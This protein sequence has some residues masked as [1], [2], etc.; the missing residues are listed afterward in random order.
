MSSGATSQS[1]AWMQ[2]FLRNKKIWFRFSA[3]RLRHPRL[4]LGLAALT[5]GAYLA[6]LIGMSARRG[7]RG[8]AMG[9]GDHTVL[10]PQG[11][12][13]ANPGAFQNDW[14]MQS[15]PQ[16]HWF[17]DVVTAFGTQIGALGA[18]YFLYWFLGLYFFALATLILSKKWAPKFPLLA[19]FAVTTIAGVMPWSLIGTGTNAI[20]MAL[21][22]VLAANMLYLS[23]ALIFRSRFGLAAILATLIALVHVQQGAVIAVI[24]LA[25][26]IGLSVREKS[27]Q[28]K[29]ALGFLGAT[30][31]VLVGLSLRPVAANLQ[32]FV[33]VCDSV[34]PYHCA[35]WSWSLSTQA[36][37][38]GILAIAA[39]TLLLMKRERLVWFLSL[40]LA[41]L[42]LSIGFILD[43]LRVPLLGEL[44]QAVN[45]Y[46]LGATVVP[47]MIWGMI[48]PALIPSNISRSRTI[49]ALVSW[50]VA[51]LLVLV[52]PAWFFQEMLITHPLRFAMVL[53]LLALAVVASRARSIKGA[54]QFSA[55]LI[56]LVILF[57]SLDAR[58]LQPVPA[59]SFEPQVSSD[60]KEWSA[61]A[62]QAIPEGEIVTAGSG[63][64]LLRL[65]IQRATIADCKNV[66]YGGEAWREWKRRISDLRADC[67][68]VDTFD[69][70]DA[71]ELVQ[72]ADKYNSD[73]IV[74]S[75]IETAEDLVSLGW[76]KVVW[77]KPSEALMVFE[78]N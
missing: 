68:G 15:A 38:V 72:L 48:L 27:L 31:F 23:L 24:F 4:A 67:A 25:L 33:E 63:G 29:P 50:S 75:N 7:W 70:I 61:E 19:A 14:F 18:I 1:P 9:I 64:S 2:G 44:A 45:V 42:G 41:L 10:A 11:I 39:M 52:E 58:N 55:L 66:P 5:L 46:R 74:L 53:V 17:F 57:A 77:S 43:A 49:V 28:V 69:S 13:W 62:R 3:W 47:F 60:L 21:P 71:R 34:I 78:R 36:S 54:R 51:F 16:P 37:T 35:A 65:V 32:D 22:T 6:V 8:Y 20:G 12:Q 30:G 56:P 59:W 40:G 26:T 76:K 73:F